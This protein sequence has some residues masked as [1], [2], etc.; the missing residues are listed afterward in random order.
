MILY[1]YIY[2]YYI[3]YSF[4][5]RIMFVFI[6][7]PLSNFILSKFVLLSLREINKHSIVLN[8]FTKASADTLLIPGICF[9]IILNMLSLV[10]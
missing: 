7:R 8:V 2:N 5:V 4:N 10:M 3:K 6:L 1:L 9:N